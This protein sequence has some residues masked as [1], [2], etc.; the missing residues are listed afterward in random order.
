MIR[1][2]PLS[3]CIMHPGVDSIV[4]VHKK[5][6]V[7]LLSLCILYNVGAVPLTEDNVVDG[8][9]QIVL[10]ELDCTGRESRLIDC[11]HRGL[12]VHNCFHSE[13]AGVRCLPSTGTVY[14][15]LK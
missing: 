5:R 8:T 10:D 11:P 1:E 4:L 13:D 6:S 9:G 12:G 3:T 2:T 15:C 7:F 14:E